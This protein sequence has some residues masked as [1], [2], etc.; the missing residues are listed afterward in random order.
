V[1][2]AAMSEPKPNVAHAEED[3][4]AWPKLRPGNVASGGPLSVCGVWQFDAEVG[5][6]VACQSGTVEAGR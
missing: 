1:N 4:V 6:D 3:E 5:V 2:K